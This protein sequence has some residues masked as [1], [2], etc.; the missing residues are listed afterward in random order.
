M[1]NRVSVAQMPKELEEILN[2]KNLITGRVLVFAAADMDANCDIRR[3][4]LILTENELIHG[5][6]NTLTTDRHFSG[7]KELPVDYNNFSFNSYEV[8]ALSNS[9]V[10]LMVVG[11]IFRLNILGNETALCGFTNAYKGRVNRLKDILNKLTEKQEIEEN[12]LF[13]EEHE[14]FCPKCGT[15]Y[16][17]ATRKICPKCMDKRKIFFRLASFFKPHTFGIVIVCIL[18]I[19]G[20]LIA[21]LW[22]YLSGSILY[23]E[24]LSKVKNTEILKMIPIN[25]FSVLLLM[26]V[27]TM[28]GLKILEQF[29]GIIK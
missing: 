25:D 6:E 19:F 14:L 9:A 1:E 3:N 29:F 11:G 8:Q 13:E 23:D 27:V 22:P 10:D 16:P 18:S 12:L 7:F 20:S 24:I 5:L 2:S 15:P 28:V 4:V 17:E 26:L 21:A